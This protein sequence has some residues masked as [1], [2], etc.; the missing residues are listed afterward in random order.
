MERA[1]RLKQVRIY[2]G[3]CF[4]V[5]IHERGW[6]IFISSAIIALIISMVI[7]GFDSESNEMF[8]LYTSTRSGTF[9]VVCA[10]IWIGIFNSIQSICKER[11]IIKREHRSGLHISSYVVAHMIYEMVLCLIESVIVTAIFCLFCKDNMN[12]DG[13]F[14]PTVVEL[15]IA[16]F[17]TI[18]ASDALGLMVSGIVKTPNTAMTVMPFVLILQLVLSGFIFELEGA[19]EKIAYVTIAK[20]SMNAICITAN[21]NSMVPVPTPEN[22]F[23]LATLENNREI[24]EFT[25]GNFLMNCGIL[26]GFALLYMIVGIIAL[27][28]VDRDKR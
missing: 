22:A 11:D 14:L 24:Y 26:V 2:V 21:V 5:F 25:A 10:C 9:A 18:Y 15:W 20:W 19:M 17:L 12:A 8:R 3:K 13:V 6:K 1:S 16:F 4:R 7:A 23:V 28:F 27:E